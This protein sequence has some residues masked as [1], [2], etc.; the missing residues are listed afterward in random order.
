MEIKLLFENAHILV[1]D[2]PSG[3]VVHGDGKRE[4][5]TLVDW[6]LEHYPEI[7]GVGEDMVVKGKAGDNIVI[8]RPGIVH[9]IDRDTSGVL[10]IAKTQASFLDL[11]KKFQNREMQKEYFALVYGWPKEEKGI[12]DIP[13]GRHRKDFRMKQTAPYA[14]GQLREAETHYE[15]LNTYFDKRKKDKQGEFEKYALLRCSPKTGRTHQIRVH[16][17]HI[18]HPIVADPLYRGK[19]KE[20]LGLSRTALHAHSIRLKDISGEEIFVSS[21]LAR[22]IQEAIDLLTEKR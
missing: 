16:L 12:I 17:K 21:P 19:R 22:D 7:E 10:V 1:I 2:K 8:A 14:R 11:K 6:V 20:T 9:R 13:I 15:M 18:H 3:L 5:S 4:E